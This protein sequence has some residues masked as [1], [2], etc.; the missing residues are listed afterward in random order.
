MLAMLFQVPGEEP[1]AIIQ[2]FALAAFGQITI[3]PVRDGFAAIRPKPFRQY[4]K[5]RIVNGDMHTLGAQE[6]HRLAS[7][8]GVIRGVDP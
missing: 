8:I 3:L 2:L 6:F 5:L 4:T 7:F 1:A